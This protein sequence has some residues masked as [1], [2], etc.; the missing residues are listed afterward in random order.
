[1]G[2]YRYHLARLRRARQWDQI[3]GFLGVELN[4]TQTIP[5]EGGAPVDAS[6]TYYF[7]DEADFVDGITFTQAMATSKKAHRCYTKKLSQYLLGRELANGE[8]EMISTLTDDSLSGASISSLVYNILHD[9]TF[10]ARGE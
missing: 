10:T 4:K 3:S 6:G 9:P 7:D 1:M 2:Q 5:E 8:E